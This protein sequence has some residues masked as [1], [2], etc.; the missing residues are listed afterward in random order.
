MHSTDG[1]L[2]S[3]AC[4]IGGTCTRR[5]PV[6]SSRPGSV[7]PAAAFLGHHGHR[8]TLPLAP[9]SLAT[10]SSRRR[11]AS[12][13]LLAPL[14]G[15]M[16][17]F[18]S[19]P[20]VPS[21]GP[22]ENENRVPMPMR[23]VPRCF[24]SMPPPPTQVP[25]KPPPARKDAPGPKPWS[26]EIPPE[27]PRYPEPPRK[28]DEG[29]HL[30]FGPWHGNHSEDHFSDHV[31]RQGFFD[32]APIGQIET[33]SAKT[34]ILPLIKQRTGPHMLSQIFTSVLG[35]RRHNGRVNKRIR[36]KLPPRV[37][38]TD[39]KREAWLEDIAKPEIPLRKLSRT[40][41]HGV[42]GKT[43][44][45]QCLKKRIPV[46]RAVWLSRT[47]GAQELRQFKRKSV[48]GTIVM[49]GEAKWIRDWTNSIEQFVE[50]VMKTSGQMADWSAKMNY[51]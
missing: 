1:V 9:L 5:G 29:R 50:S 36:F 23:M 19:L 30:D 27:A 8:L 16:A 21:Q 12:R 7:P 15:P 41:P 31:I 17:S 33:S 51:S 45:E 38:V 11:K 4:H 20:P 35:Q 49:G 24:A 3:R 22:A 13:P 37:A 34:A 2:R 43:L 46:D 39:S 28:V 40:I 14:P 18:K 26:I 25:L 42:R 6:P 10:M 32:K 47:V 44:L 48:N